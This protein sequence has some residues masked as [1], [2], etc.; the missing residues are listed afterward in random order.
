MPKESIN[1][2]ARLAFSKAPAISRGY[3]DSEALDPWY[4]HIRDSPRPGHFRADLVEGMEEGTSARGPTLSFAGA[5]VLQLQPGQTL[6]GIVQPGL[7]GKDAGQFFDGWSVLPGFLS[8]D[9]V[10]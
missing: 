8:Q 10:W 3:Y 5:K 9:Q 1:D 2:A 4:F 6:R 7:R